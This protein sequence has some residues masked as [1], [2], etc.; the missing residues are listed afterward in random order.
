M[1]IISPQNTVLS[2]GENTT[3]EEDFDLTQSVGNGNQSFTDA[4]EIAKAE[5]LYVDCK[6]LFENLQKHKKENNDRVQKMM[7]D[8]EK[9]IDFAAKEISDTPDTSIIRE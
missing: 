7:Q 6:D 9:I 8:I 2:V 4:K 3:I 1:S 5:E